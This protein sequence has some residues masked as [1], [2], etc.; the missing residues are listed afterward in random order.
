MSLKAVEGKKYI[1]KLDKRRASPR[2]TK[3][4]ISKKRR[5]IVIEKPK[6]RK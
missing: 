6:E 2:R 4:G 3:L 1:N 5:V